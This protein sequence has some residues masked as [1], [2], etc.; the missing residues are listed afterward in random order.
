[1]QIQNSQLK[2]LFKTPKRKTYTLIT[3]TTILIGLSVFFVIRPTF[4]KISD[5]NKEIADK[6]EFLTKVEAKLET[7]NNLIKQKDT[8]PEE[9]ADFERS[10]VSK[11]KSGFM[12]ANLAAIANDNDIILKS[13]EFEDV[14]VDFEEF[15]V[16]EQVGITNISIQLEGNYETLE[17]Y[18]KHLESFPR[19]LDVRQITYTGIEIDD[20]EDD[21]ASYN[22]VECFISMYLFTWEEVPEGS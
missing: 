9:L 19:I 6:R 1:M 18:L 4:V 22:P 7:V 3:I 21:I 8:I 13:V 2:E 11:E 20:F 17:N 15:D 14:E 10:F 12:I 5:L 16:P